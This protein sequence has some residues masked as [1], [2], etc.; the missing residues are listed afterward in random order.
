MK[1]KLNSK[2]VLEIAKALKNGWLDTGKIA[3]FQSLLDGYNPPKEIK[4]D[5]LN[6]YLDCLYKGWGYKPTDKET[7]NKMMLQ[8]L[9]GEL[10]EK[11]QNHIENNSMYKIMVKEVFWGMVA[12]KALGGTFT[13]IEPDFSFINKEPPAHR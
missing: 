4:R 6:Y 9:D 3:S 12:I 8:G 1:I 2:D 7:I 13:D 5:E 11:W 10:L